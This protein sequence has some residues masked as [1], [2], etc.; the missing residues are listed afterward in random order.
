MW[1]VTV[2]GVAGVLFSL[3][4]GFFPPDNLPVG[5]PVLYVSMVAGG[6]ILFTAVPLLIHHYRKNIVIC[7]SEIPQKGSACNNQSANKVI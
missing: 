3:I 5:N 2:I 7:R 4:V 6:L 1:L